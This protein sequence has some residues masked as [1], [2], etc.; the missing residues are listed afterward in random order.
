MKL[1]TLWHFITP[2]I[3]QGRL[4]SQANSQVL[5]DIIETEPSRFWGEHEK[6]INQ[7]IKQREFHYPSIRK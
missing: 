2:D 3:V 1:S 6:I 5:L 7:L 4:R